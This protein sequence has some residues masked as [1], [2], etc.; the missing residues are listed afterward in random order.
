MRLKVLLFLFLILGFTEIILVSL[1]ID[2]S[3]ILRPLCALLIYAFYYFNSHRHNLY[4]IIYLSCEL[5][6]ETF[7]LINFE[8]YFSLVL[9]GYVLATFT[10][11]YHLWPVFKKVGFTLDRDALF[12]TILGL[13]GIL[14]AFWELTLLVFDN[15]PDNVIFFPALAAL[16]SWIFFC[17]IIPI[18]NRHPDNFLLYLMG[19][20]MAVMA[21]TMFIYTFLWSYVP[22]LILCLLSMMLLKICMVWYLIK[23]DDILNSKES[24]F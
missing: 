10:M 14:Y 19:G 1:E 20:S 3:I 2:N 8:R 13:T 4:F 7:F 12:K 15:L 5:I 18:R 9:G 24:Y 16:I 23:L 17:S 6:N 11:I 21:P 22:V